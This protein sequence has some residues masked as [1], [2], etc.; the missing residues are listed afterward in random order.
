MKKSGLLFFTFFIILLLVMSG[1]YA[2]AADKIGFIDVRGIM[3]QSEAGKKASQ[4][5]RKAFEKDKAKIQKEETKLR[6]L[7]EELD[8]QRPILTP[9]AIKEKEVAYQKKFR[10]YQRLVKDSNEELQLKDRELS[11]KLIPEIL[12]VV[13]IIGKKEKYTIILDVNTQGVAYYSKGNNITEK[14]IKEF[15][16]TYKAGK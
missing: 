3:I 11:R 7:K 12:K 13:D 6:K 5:F 2:I 4:E 10:D 1:S 15:N 8:K 16:R 9:A 14:V